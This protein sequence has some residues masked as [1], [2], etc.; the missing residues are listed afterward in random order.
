MVGEGGGWPCHKIGGEK[1]AS[2]MT[3]V[4]VAVATDCCLCYASHST[5]GGAAS[6]G[7][8]HGGRGDEKK[9]EG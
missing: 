4:G 9:G 3:V 7:T 6:N 5:A 8:S 1:S 2:V